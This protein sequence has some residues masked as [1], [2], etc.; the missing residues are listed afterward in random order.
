MEIQHIKICKTQ[1]KQCQKKIF[2]A[3]NAYFRK[4][5][6]SQIIIF[7]LKKLEKEQNKPKA[8][9]MKDVIKSRNQ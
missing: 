8:G 7:Y 1:L 5:K 2:L 6:K 4:E 9:G 3:L